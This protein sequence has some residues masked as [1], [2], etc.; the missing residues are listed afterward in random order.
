MQPPTV[1]A[2]H[3]GVGKLSCLTNSFF[4]GRRTTTGGNLQ[5]CR[6]ASCPQLQNDM[7][8]LD[9][10]FGGTNC[11]NE[12]PFSFDH[13]IDQPQQ[14]STSPR[15]ARMISPHWGL[16]PGPS[17]YRTDALPLSYRGRERRKSASGSEP[18]HTQTTHPGAIAS[19]ERGNPA[20]PAT[21]GVCPGPPRR[22]VIPAPSAFSAPVIC[23]C[24]LSK[25]SPVRPCGLMDKA[26][27]FGTKDCRFESCQG[28]WVFTVC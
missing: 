11:A 22:R 4:A 1:P 17:V 14:Q 26:L 21:M 2:R 19:A 9:K 8:E 3:R 6:F 20:R 23:V 5:T 13:A 25:M 18:Q 10:Q 7:D 12:R 16:N 27:V 15:A 28:H 24:A